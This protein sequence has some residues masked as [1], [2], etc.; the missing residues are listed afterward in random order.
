MKRAS[1]TIQRSARLVFAILLFPLLARATSLQSQVEELLKPR[2]APVSVAPKD[3]DA[4]T[5]T[6]LA[7]PDP[8]TFFS[9][10]IFGLQRNAAKLLTLE[11]T[12]RLKRI[13][14]N[15]SPIGLRWHDERNTLRCNSTKSCGATPA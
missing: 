2:L 14:E 8:E 13:I 3:A 7:R 12:A 9:R 15:R 5:A 6:V 1:F 10:Y 4:V 11:Q